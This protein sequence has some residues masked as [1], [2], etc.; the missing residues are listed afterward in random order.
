MSRLVFA[1][2][3]CSACLSRALLCSLS[4][5][6]RSSA[7]SLLCLVKAESN[8]YSVL[9]IEGLRC[10]GCVDKVQTALR[11]YDP[12]VRVT[13]TPPEVRFSSPF[14][15][16]EVNELLSSIGD[17][18]VYPHGSGLSRISS[19]LSIY[20]PL[21]GVFLVLTITTV[22]LQ[23]GSSTF[24]VDLAM[25]QFMGLYFLVFASFKIMNLKGFADSFRKYDLLAYRSEVY[26]R[27]YPLLELSL[28]YFYLK[29]KFPL[30]VNILSFLLMT[31]SS[32]GV[33][34]ALIQKR[35]IACACL[36]TVFNLPMTYVSLFE[37]LLMSAMALITILRLKVFKR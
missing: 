34:I 6:P 22:G 31:F 21:I 33:L 11:V 23:L 17:Y 7:V 16:Q 27:L 20:S 1:F 25:Q 5:P 18:K 28:G 26:A 14:R 10:M 24:N 8:D 36:G 13:L 2:F 12:D 35:K 37:D 9:S 4:S 32:V 19:S 30:T 29:N 15:I 3:Y